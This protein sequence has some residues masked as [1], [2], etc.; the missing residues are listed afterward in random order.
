MSKKPNPLSKIRPGSGY[1]KDIETLKAE[2]GQEEK[3]TKRFNAE[4]PASLH[5]AI[6]KRAIDEGLPMNELAV[7]IFTEYLSRGI[8]E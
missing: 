1:H 7:K 2:M 5:A 4:I 6:K 8:R 3:K